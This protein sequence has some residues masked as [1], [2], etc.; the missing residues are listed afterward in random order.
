MYYEFYLDVYFLENFIVNVLILHLTEELLKERISWAR[1]CFA[2]ASG[3]AASCA[4]VLLPLYKNPA[5]SGAAACILPAMALSA[6]GGRK[7]ARIFCPVCAIALLLGGVWQILRVRFGMPF[8]LAAPAGYL[9]VKYLWKF[10][11]RLRGRTQY[12]YDVTLQKDG[13]KACLRGLLDSGNRLVQPVTAKP[14]HIIEFE[15]IRKLLNDRE[16]SELLSWLRL[17]AEAEGSGKFTYIPYRSIGD[18]AGVL[19]AVTLDGI[20][21]R[22][23]K[24][25]WSTKEPLVAVSRQA[26][27][28]RGEYQ[29]ILHPSILE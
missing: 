5:L 18:N 14:V 8:Y 16:Q 20:C 22:H 24:T 29:M 19:P 11:R 9:S 17:E 10:W 7:I 2:A 4:A 26:V 3:A 12:I 21:I 15:Q 6:A 13:K 23:G 1:M 25:A 28:S 27:S